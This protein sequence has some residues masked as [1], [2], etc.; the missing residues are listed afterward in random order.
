MSEDEK[1]AL[2]RQI[3]P[4]CGE[5]AELVDAALCEMAD[6]STVEPGSTFDSLVL[7][8]GSFRLSEVLSCV[9]AARYAQIVGDDLS[10]PRRR[11]SGGDE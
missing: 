3:M 8:D 2:W 7:V 5:M 10:L 1:K 9:L 11:Y 4:G 6:H